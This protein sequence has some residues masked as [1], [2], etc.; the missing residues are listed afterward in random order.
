MNLKCGALSSLTPDPPGKLDVLGH[1]GH[2]LG[3]NGT[4][5]GVFEETNK[6]GLS[7]FLKSK[8]SGGLEPK[9]SLEVLGNFPNKTLEGQLADKKLSGLLVPPDFTEGHSTGTVTVRLLNTT[10]YGS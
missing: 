5:V 4:Q 2:T 10:S 8:N 6:V 9:V 1:D 3:V 7:S